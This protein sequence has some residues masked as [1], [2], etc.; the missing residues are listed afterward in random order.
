MKVLHISE[1]IKGG[2]ATYI[3]ELYQ[4]KHISDNFILFAPSSHQKHL[5]KHISEDSN[6]K[7]FNR[8]SRN[9]KS[10]LLFFIFIV[11][12]IKKVKPDI[13]HLHGT[14]AGFFVRIY[15][16]FSFN[17]PIIIYCSHGWSFLMDIGIIKRKFYLLIERLLAY[18]TDA[19]INISN[20]DYDQSL[21]LGFSYHKSIKITNSINSIINK[22]N[23]RIIKYSKNKV[24]F[25]FVGRLDKQK[26]FD[27]LF[28][29]F[30]YNK[31]YVLHVVGDFV[32]SKSKKYP[33]LD[34]IFSYGWINAEDIHNC[35]IDSDV[36]IIPSRWEGFGLVAIEAMKYSKPLIVSNRGALPEI[37][38]DGINGFIFNFDNFDL[39]LSKKIDSLSKLGLNLAGENSKRLFNKYYSK[40]DMV[41]KV[42]KLYSNLLDKR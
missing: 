2:I 6:N 14:F 32:N 41:Y 20:F 8:K 1:C 39:S 15:Y 28:K 10:L 13:I 31:D 5:F 42:Y 18:K 25:L 3:N 26:G 33:N 27:K 19:I 38:Q 22:R 36:V 34:N 30:S 29:Y 21:K 9:I 24:N 17:R 11:R 7:F 37:V 35:Y 4:N 12:N 16:A 23:N 40:N